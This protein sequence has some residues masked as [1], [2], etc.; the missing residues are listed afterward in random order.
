ME[1]Y[2]TIHENKVLI[3]P[4]NKLNFKKM[5]HPKVPKDI[6]HAGVDIVKTASD[7]IL[8]DWKPKTLFGRI[9]K[10]VAKTAISIG[11]GITTKNINK[12]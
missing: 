2:K 9:S 8:K 4:P 1:R 5:K 12:Q 10:F 11:V 3:N 6:Q 7:E